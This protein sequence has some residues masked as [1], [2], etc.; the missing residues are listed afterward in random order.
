VSSVTYMD[1]MFYNVTLSTANY[2]ALL[3]GW[4]HETLRPGVSFD[5]GNSMYSGAASAARSYIINTY[6]WTIIDGGQTGPNE[7]NPNSTG[8]AAVT[9]LAGLVGVVIVV[10]WIVKKK[11]QIVEREQPREAINQ[12]RIKMMLMVPSAPQY[13]RAR[14]EAGRVFLSWQPPASKWGSAITCYKVYRGSSRGDEVLI[15]TLGNVTTFTDTS[16]ASGQACHYRVS[17]VNDPG[18]GVL[19]AEAIANPPDAEGP[20][21]DGQI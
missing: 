17:A 6:D 9:V 2:D 18:E 19:S 5:A 11:H 7:P 1:D 10:G 15:A 8:I 4:S 14:I 3:L 13:L 21:P 20:V 16:M 12:E